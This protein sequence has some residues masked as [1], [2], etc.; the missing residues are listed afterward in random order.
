MDNQRRHDAKQ[1]S[2]APRKE[3]SISM[4]ADVPVWHDC[5]CCEAEPYWLEAMEEYEKQSPPADREV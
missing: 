3:K 2:P 4:H 1:K 5:C